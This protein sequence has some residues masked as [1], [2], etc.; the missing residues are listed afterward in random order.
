[1]RRHKIG[2]LK[3]ENSHQNLSKETKRLGDRIF[4]L[5]K[6]IESKILKMTIKIPQK[7]K[8]LTQKMSRV[9]RLILQ[10]LYLILLTLKD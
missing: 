8:F 10:F 3:S 7:E 6:N 1:M 2:S 9:D 4:Q 5:S